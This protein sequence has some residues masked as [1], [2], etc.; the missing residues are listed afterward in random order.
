MNLGVQL[1][2]GKGW[3]FGSG[4]LGV[5]QFGNE[6]GRAWHVWECNH[7]ATKRGAQPYESGSATIRQRKRVF[8]V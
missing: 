6:G 8:S 2:H 5:Q 4:N 3:I 7:W 1:F